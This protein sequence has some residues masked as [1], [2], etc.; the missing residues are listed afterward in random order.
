MFHKK[1]KDK[2]GDVATRVEGQ[3]TSQAR[4]SEGKASW[5]DPGG[6]WGIEGVILA[7]QPG[8]GTEGPCLFKREPE[9][10]NNHPEKGAK[11]QKKRKSN[12]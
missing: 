8:S 1:K 2:K 7:I 9:K 6:Y 3:G 10:K 4:V 12:E 5:R 11:H